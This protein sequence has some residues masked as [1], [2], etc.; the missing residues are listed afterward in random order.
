MS[1]T[2]AWVILAGITLLELAAQTALLYTSQNKEAYPL[3]LIVGMLLYTASGYIV[4]ALLVMKE[5][6]VFINLGWNIG[7][8][9]VGA[10]LGFLVM[11]ETVT[12]LKVSALVLGTSSLALWAYAEKMDD[13]AAKVKKR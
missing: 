4:Y 8:M 9:F 12:P 5:S 2:K 6:V 13:K 10:I 1:S 11:K 7:S 3:G